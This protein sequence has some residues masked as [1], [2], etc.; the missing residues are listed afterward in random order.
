MDRRNLPRCCG[1]ILLAGLTPGY[2]GAANYEP[3]VVSLEDPVTNAAPPARSAAVPGAAGASVAA[4]SASTQAGS[5]PA[6]SYD[7]RLARRYQSNAVTTLKQN[8]R[9][10]GTG[11]KDAY[12]HGDHG[13]R[14]SVGSSYHMRYRAS[15]VGPGAAAGTAALMRLPVG[16]VNLRDGYENYAP[17][18]MVGYDA[19]VSERMKVG[20]EGGMMVG[21]STAMYADETVPGIREESHTARNPV[22]DLVMTYAF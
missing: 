5:D 12:A 18:A 3:H 20:I 13:L 21:R 22:A 16:A 19:A 15:D 8:L 9:A 10:R 1:A 6:A 14:V 4:L 7:L 17:V 11:M 2:A